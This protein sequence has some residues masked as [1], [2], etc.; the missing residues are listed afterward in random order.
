METKPFLKWHFV[1]Q[2]KLPS[3]SKNNINPFFISLPV[4]KNELLRDHSLYHT[5][6]SPNRINRLNEIFFEII[7]LGALMHI[8]IFLIAMKKVFGIFYKNVTND[9]D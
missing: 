1:N 8:R 7:P 2:N 9:I 5:D 3:F 4:R 6:L